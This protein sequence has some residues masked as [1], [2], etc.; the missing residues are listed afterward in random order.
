MGTYLA[1]LGKIT[2]AVSENHDFLAFNRQNDRLKSRNWKIGLSYDTDHLSTRCIEKTVCSYLLWSFL[3]GLQRKKRSKK[4]APLRFKIIFSSDTSNL[5]FDLQ[6][7][8]FF[9]FI[10]LNVISDDKNTCVFKFQDSNFRNLIVSRFQTNVYPIEKHKFET[11]ANG[12]IARKWQFFFRD[13]L[14]QSLKI[15]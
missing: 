3:D 14:I 8:L 15:M 4:K 9:K 10:S 13:R 2:G 5:F 12:I 11:S 6:K 1:S 7:S